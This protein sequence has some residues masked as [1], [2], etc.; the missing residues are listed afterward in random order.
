MVLALLTAP[1]SCQKLKIMNKWASDDDR[2]NLRENGSESLVVKVVT[3]LLKS[4][5]SALKLL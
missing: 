5:V 2:H 3:F 1:T 4:L